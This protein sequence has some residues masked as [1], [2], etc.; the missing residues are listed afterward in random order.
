MAFAE[1][2]GDL[3]AYHIG[4]LLKGRIELSTEFGGNLVA[5]VYELAE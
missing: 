4:V 2:V 5:H 1:V 3:A